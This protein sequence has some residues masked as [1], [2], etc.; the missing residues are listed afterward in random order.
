MPANISRTPFRPVECPEC[1]GARHDDD[2]NCPTCDG[3][4][5]VAHDLA[6]A[7]LEAL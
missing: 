7:Y 1:F 2:R 4:G 3:A 6:D 5:E